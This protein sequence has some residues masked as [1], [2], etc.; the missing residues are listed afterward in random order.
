MSE[1]ARADR[2]QMSVEQGIAAG[3]SMGAAV[4]LITLGVLSLFQ[5]IAA[6]AEDEVF[7]R[8]LEYIYRFDVTGWGWIH[9]V[10]G[11]LMILVGIAL[12]TG[13]TWAR[14]TAIVLAALSIV[15]NFLWL[16]YYPWW[17]ILIIALDIVVIWA[18]STWNPS[19]ASA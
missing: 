18:I 9:I 5:G 1:H 11:V 13:A 12:M 10:V 8:G 15:A 16:P 3:T 6:V 19:R 2:E 7:V 4:I 14:A 17:S